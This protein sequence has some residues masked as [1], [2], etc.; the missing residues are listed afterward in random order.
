[1]LPEGSVAETVGGSLQPNFQLIPF[2]PGDGML[3]EPGFLGNTQKLLLRFFSQKTAVQFYFLP[4][5]QGL[6]AFLALGTLALAKPNTD[7][8]LTK[9]QYKES[10]GIEYPLQ[11]RDVFGVGRVSAADVGNIVL[12]GAVMLRKLKHSQSS[13]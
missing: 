4:K 10:K 12:I 2:F 6:G 9:D 7:A 11:P 5:C 13:A 1:M 3:A 8:P